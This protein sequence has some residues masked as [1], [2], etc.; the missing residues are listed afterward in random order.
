MDDKTHELAVLK[1]Q[2]KIKIV[3]KFPVLILDFFFTKQECDSMLEELIFLRSALSETNYSALDENGKP[4]AK[5][6]QF[7]MDGVFQDRNLSRCLSINR[8]LFDLNFVNEWEKTN[9]F[10]R[11]LKAANS[12]TTLINYYENEHFYAP[13]FDR[14]VITAITWLYERP[15][16]FTG[17]DLILEGDTTIKVKHGRTVLLPSFLSHSVTTVQCAQSGKGRWA[18]TQFFKIE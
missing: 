1:A 8:K 18:M 12:D 7:W 13:H 2:A 14:A 3:K 4:K 11:N 5:K 10:W 9:I 6:Q 17:G 16:Q 15:K